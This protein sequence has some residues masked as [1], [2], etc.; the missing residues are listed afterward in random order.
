[1]VPRRR[2]WEGRQAVVEERTHVIFD[3]EK[4]IEGQFQGQCLGSAMM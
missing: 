4:Y 3:R 1:M 2:T